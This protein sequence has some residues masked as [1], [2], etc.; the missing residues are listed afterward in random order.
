MT[1]TDGNQ[2]LNKFPS[3]N[4][5][6]PR[7]IIGI[8]WR[9]RSVTELCRCTWFLKWWNI[10]RYTDA[11]KHLLR[12][13]S[14]EWLTHSQEYVLD[15]IR[16]TQI[17]LKWYTIWCHLEATALP[18]D[19]QITATDPHCEKNKSLEHCVSNIWV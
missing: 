18:A 8:W 4:E 9:W 15:R 14:N 16:M 11:T 7:I 12:D 1:Y 2:K 3:L 19:Q 6:E 13:N 17:K 10:Y 5:K